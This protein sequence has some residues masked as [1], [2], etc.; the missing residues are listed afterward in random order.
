MVPENVREF[1]RHPA[2]VPIKVASEKTPEQLNLKLNNVSA[3][4]LSFESPQRFSEGT[5]VKIRIPSTKP[6]FRVHA[7]VEWCRG[8]KDVF[9]LGVRFLDQDDAFRVRMVEQV[10]HIEQYRKSLQE[11]EGR[12]ISR[13][14]ASYEWIAKNGGTFPR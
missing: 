12:R 13:N 5:V 9:E 14:R 4:G 6:V 8:L 7:I 2:Q 11:T 1:I 10:C 3:G